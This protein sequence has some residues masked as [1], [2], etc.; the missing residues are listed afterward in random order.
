MLC[1]RKDCRMRAIVYIFSFISFGLFVRYLGTGDSVTKTRKQTALKG[2][3]SASFRA[4]LRNDTFYVTTWP[5]A[6]FTNQFMGYVNMIYLATIT[7]RTPILPPFIPYKII[8]TDAGLLPFGDVFDLEHLSSQLRIS[9]LEWRDVKKL[10]T[11]TDADPYLYV[12]NSKAHLSESLGCWSTK[13]SYES[14]PARCN[15]LVRH[16]GVDVAYTRVPATT[17]YKPEDPK[18]IHVVFSQLAALIYRSPSPLFSDLGRSPF[19]DPKEHPETFDYMSPSPKG[20]DITPEHHLACFDSLYY[21]TS[22]ASSFEWK[23]GFSPAWRYVGR[24]LRF[25][26][27]LQMLTQQYLNTLFPKSIP[28]FIAVHARR[29]DFD[30]PCGKHLCFPPLSV[31]QKQVD[32]VRKELGEILGIEVNNV[33]LMSDET[34]P[35]FWAN[36]KAIGWLSVDHGTHL[37]I[38]RYG[39]WY[40]TLIDIVI[41]SCAIGFVGTEDSTLSIVSQRRVMD[42]NGGAIRS[43]NIRDLEQYSS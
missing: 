16:I 17:R 12:P 5:S 38:E 41:Q 22:G 33:V 30:W 37:T 10:P 39:P 23:Y 8:G 1:A 25:S 29:G 6:G 7:E 21:V 31:Y 11:P 27:N 28:P 40:P 4:N 26:E 35:E 19:F 18:E 13:A 9:V 43:V 15:Q 14:Q 20:L 36:V 32:V 3:P 2:L 34:A 42:W 24:Y